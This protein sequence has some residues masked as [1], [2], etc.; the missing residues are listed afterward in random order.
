MDAEG[1]EFLLDAVD[2]FPVLEGFADRLDHPDPV[3][4]HYLLEKGSATQ[5][6]GELNGVS[7]LAQTEDE[8]AAADRQEG[9]QRFRDE[10]PTRSAQ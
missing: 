3:P 2:R 1:M 8:G 7:G 5:D 10:Y 4:L 9:D 6:V